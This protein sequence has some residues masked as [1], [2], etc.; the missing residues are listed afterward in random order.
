MS[1]LEK[2]FYV[3][4][5]VF[6]TI[7]LRKAMHI[8]KF[9][10]LENLS[11]LSNIQTEESKAD[12]FEKPP[13]SKSKIEVQKLTN[14]IKQSNFLSQ[15][16]FNFKPT[17]NNPL[18]DYIYRENLKK[19]QKLYE[20]IEIGDVVYLK[21]PFYRRKK[22]FMNK[23]AS[24]KS[25]K[26]KKQGL[27]IAD[28]NSLFLALKD[29]MFHEK[30]AYKIFKK[31]LFR[32]ESDGISKPKIP[33]AYGDKINFRHL[34]SNRL[35]SIKPKT[36]NK[37]GGLSFSLEEETTKYTHFQINP[38]DKSKDIGDA[39]AFY[40]KILIGNMKSTRFWGVSLSQHNERLEVS[41]LDNGMLFKLCRYMKGEEFERYE[42]CKGEKLRNGD[43]LM[44]R[45]RE[46]KG[47]LT[48]GDW[49]LRKALFESKIKVYDSDEKFNATQIIF[50]LNQLNIEKLLDCYQEIEIFL[51]NNPSNFNHFWEIQYFKPFQSLIFKYSD[52]FR[53]RNLATGLYLAVNKTT[54]KLLL[55]YQL[56]ETNE[57]VTEFHF[58]TLNLKE[59]LGFHRNVKLKSEFQQRLLTMKGAKGDGR[60]N[61]AF[62]PK[63]S[64]ETWRYSF[65]ICPVS[66]GLDIEGVERITAVFNTFLS[67]HFFLQ[68]FGMIEQ[69]NNEKNNNEF[70]LKYDYDEAMLQEMALEA[71]INRFESSC[72]SLIEFLRPSNLET[73]RE[74]QLS[75]KE[76]K[77][78]ELLILLAKIIDILIYSNKNSKERRQKASKNQ[79]PAFPSPEKSPFFIA[80]KHLEIQAKVIYRLLCLAIKSNAVTSNLLLEHGD[81]LSSQLYVYPKEVSLLLR[82]ALRSVPKELLEDNMQLLD[83]LS[84]LESLNELGNNIEEQTE[85][86]DIL[87]TALIDNKEKSVRI[88]QQRIQLELFSHRGGSEM[89]RG[90]LRFAFL[91]E[92]PVIIFKKESDLKEFLTS[93][94]SLSVLSLVK[95]KEN[96]DF[97]AFYLEELIEKI[98]FTQHIRYISSVLTMIAL[99]IKDR[100][101]KV[102]SK[103][104]SLGISF[105]HILYCLK[106]PRFPLKLKAAYLLLYQNL[107][108]DREPFVPISKYRNRCVLWSN[109]KDF[110][111]INPTY[112]VL[113]LEDLQNPEVAGG[114]VVNQHFLDFEGILNEFWSEKGFIVSWMLSIDLMNPVMDR[115]E[116]IYVF[117]QVT[118]NIIDLGYT[119]NQF[120]QKV[121][122]FIARIF[123]TLLKEPPSNFWLGDVLKEAMGSD[124]E[125]I[126]E[127][128]EDLIGKIFFEATKILKV[129]YQVLE[130]VQINVFM[131]MFKENFENFT[132]KPSFDYLFNLSQTKTQTNFIKTSQIPTKTGNSS[133]FESKILNYESQIQSKG[134]ANTPKKTSE[135]SKTYEL[136]ISVW[137]FLL[138]KKRVPPKTLKGLM[139][140]VLRYS[141]L[142][143]RLFEELKLIELIDGKKEEELYKELD[144]T[145]ILFGQV[146]QG[147]F[148][149]T[150]TIYIFIGR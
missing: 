42:S 2:E 132:T 90:L 19:S 139:K 24:K 66:A 119:T 83:W 65:E 82:N 38:G 71:E 107:Y 11:S 113:N 135:V 21:H 49:S 26:E 46:N 93:N 57:N 17:P 117:L 12:S 148:I 114:K 28:S 121:F 36:F 23:P 111:I 128:K 69:E 30:N 50:S 105:N 75:L 35:I 18:L 134:G 110:S 31:A 14:G 25:G 129:Y 34:Y 22:D 79:D 51:Q 88:N 125:Q 150:Y 144:G 72:D 6:N 133:R 74:R 115:L 96:E 63:K 120:N 136:G 3:L 41:C 70:H 122:I 76:L 143:K 80:K 138:Q 1:F 58:E 98:D 131:Q 140:V 124:T 78:I 67:F 37:N 29:G 13:H 103:V 109:I 99:L 130:I 54:G 147:I 97:S 146:F 40:E 60:M 112:H 39:I 10:L 77:I 48:V 145:P 92:K 16:P 89:K 7:L 86:I 32:I 68:S 123:E 85:L 33:I 95:I 116:F 142:R 44:L 64:G 118:R 141:F 59:T 91:N 47:L 101:M 73:Y 94:P 9:L 149:K 87:A 4:S 53:L 127:E 43:I 100:N 56:H 27:V 137:L 62:E 61:V 45:N 126:E 106:S 20:K 81:F 15:N 8:L 104:S 108:L 52:R 55:T 5:S 102:I 84:S